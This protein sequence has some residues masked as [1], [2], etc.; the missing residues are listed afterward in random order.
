MDL[1]NLLKKCHIRFSLRRFRLS[2]EKHTRFA[3]CVYKITYKLH[4]TREALQVK[5]LYP[6]YFNTIAGDVEMVQILFKIFFH[7]P[8]SFQFKKV[9]PLN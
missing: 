3:I 2:T 4:E 5:K 8:I 7:K 6:L 1:A 9:L